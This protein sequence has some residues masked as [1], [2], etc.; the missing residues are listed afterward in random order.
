MEGYRPEKMVME[1]YRFYSQTLCSILA[2]LSAESTCVEWKIAWVKKKIIE[3][4]G[5]SQYEE[6]MRKFSLGIY[7]VKYDE[8]PIQP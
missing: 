3:G 8:M 4:L 2:M 6:K 7:S 5:W 1:F